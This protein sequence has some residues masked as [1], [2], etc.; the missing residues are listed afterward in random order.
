MKTRIT[1]HTKLGNDPANAFERM[2]TKVEDLPFVP[3]PGMHLGPLVWIQFEV[4]HSAFITGE[5]VVEIQAK[6]T[7]TFETDVEHIAAKLLEAGWVETK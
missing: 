5:A 6:Q 2:F 3:M 4:Y 7:S 1:L